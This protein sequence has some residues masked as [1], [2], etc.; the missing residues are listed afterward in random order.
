MRSFAEE[1]KS[2]TFRIDKPI[3]VWQLVLGKFMAIVV[4]FTVALLPTAIHLWGLQKLM[5]VGTPL[6]WEVS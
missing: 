5:Q 2:G 3:S 4:V 6:D 1:I